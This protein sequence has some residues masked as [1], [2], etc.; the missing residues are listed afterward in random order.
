MKINLIYSPGLVKSKLKLHAVYKLVPKTIK[1]ESTQNYSKFIEVHIFCKLESLTRE[2]V[3]SCSVFSGNSARR[4]SK[5][6]SFITD[7]IKMENLH[8]YEEI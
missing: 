2:L 8:L 1:E 7:E 4:A 6:P 3:K 5:Q